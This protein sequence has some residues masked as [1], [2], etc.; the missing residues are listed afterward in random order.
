MTLNPFLG[1][2]RE[3]LDYCRVLLQLAAA[4]GSF[5]AAFEALDRCVGNEQV[6]IKLWE[7]N[8]KELDKLADLAEFVQACGGAEEAQQA[9]RDYG[10]LDE[11]SSGS[12]H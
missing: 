5:E 1:M 8:A 4:L 2:D 6:K 11:E 12:G 9:I 7:L 3:Q 10:D